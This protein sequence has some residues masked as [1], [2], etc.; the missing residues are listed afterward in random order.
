M[1]VEPWCERVADFGAIGL[2]AAGVVRRVGFHRSETTGGGA[3]RGLRPLP[4]APVEGGMTA[5]EM[6]ALHAAVRAAGEWLLAEGY[7]GP[8]GIDAWRWTDD[9]GQTRFHALGE[10]NARLTFG[11]VARRLAEAA[12]WD[13]AAGVPGPMLRVGSEGDLAAAEPTAVLLQPAEPDGVGAWV[14]A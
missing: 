9:A 1:I 12:G 5:D 8:F 10:L 11:F 14:E 2:V 3:F 6:E 4:E 13:P 7:E